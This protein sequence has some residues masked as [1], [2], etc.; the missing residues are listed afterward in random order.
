MI[1]VFGIGADGW[2]SLSVQAREA[3]RGAELLVGG[4]RHL[5]L[6]PADVGGRR[7]PW[8]EQLATLVDE[9]PALA[10]GRS[11]V[12]LASGDPLLHGVGVTILRRLAD[13][14]VRSS[15]TSHRSR[16]RA[17]GC[18]GSRQA[19]S[20]SPRRVASPRSSSPRCS[21]GAG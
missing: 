9:L 19:R 15:R 8:P 4:D 10:D 20:S 17:R 11:I 21:P 5:A 7:R 14:H 12:V 3:V 6:V 18:A 13:E 1:T 16:L 2:S